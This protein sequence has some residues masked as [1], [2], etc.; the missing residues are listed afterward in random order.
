MRAVGLGDCN[1]SVLAAPKQ[2]ARSAVRHPH[3]ATPA[4]RIEYEWDGE[5]TEWYI[6]DQRG[7]EHGYTLRERPA[8]AAEF[9]HFSLAV[10]G[11]LDPRVSANKRD[12]QFVNTSGAATVNYSNLTVFD[13]NG[14]IVPA[15]FEAAD[16]NSQTFRI[17]VD[18]SNAVYPITIDPVAH[19]AYL[20]A[21]NTGA[22]TSGDRFGNSVAVSGD[23]VV[24]GAYEEDGGATGVNG[25]QA[26]NDATN[27]GAVYVFV[28]VGGVWSQQAYLKASNTSPGDQF[29]HSVAIS[30]D[31]V[32]VGAIAEDS[33]ATGV[34]GDQANNSALT[35]GA[36]YVFVRVGGVWSQQAYLKASNT[37]KDDRY[38]YAVSVSGD[39]VVVGAPEEDSGTMGVN[40]NGADNTAFESGAAYVYVRNAGV[41]SQ[42]AYLKPLDTWSTDWFGCAVSASGDSVVVGARFENS[43]AT[44]VNG[45]AFDASQ[46]DS[47]AAYVFVNVGGVW[48]QQAYLKASNTWGNDQ[49]GTA[50][51][52]NGDTVVVGSWAEDS[53]ATGVNGNQANNDASASGAAYVFFRSGGVWSQQAY[54]KASN[55]DN[56]DHFAFAV[57]V[58]GDTIVVGAQN[59]A[60]GATGVNGNEADESANISGAAYVFVRNGAVWTQHAYLKASNTEE[61][62]NFGRDVAIDGATIVVGAWMEDSSATGVNGNGADNSMLGSGAAYVF[63]IASPCTGD[64]GGDGTV[65]GADLGVLL[66]AWGANPGS[67]ADLNQDGV[68]NGADLG[69]LLGAWGG[70][71]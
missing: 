22:L 68:V 35:S 48:S 62:D 12:V 29:G 20:K 64:L 46:L 60:S 49:F 55:S 36:A 70:C 45:N 58:S 54:L 13:A 41:W 3:S 30:G 53:N 69:I 47:G 56:T 31:T 65:G 39:V 34:N 15:W 9:L 44:G 8:G 5:L 61:D 51:D 38:G 26:G 14:V 71:P 27:A 40:G 32:V 37:E 50:V 17:V 1:L 7:L 52:M 23:T 11:D 28:R 19:Q 21:S 67:P 59:E 2:S 66:G 42:Q 16:P 24:V 63:S 57:A 43:N 6:N 33:N 18:D 25:N 10:R 4:K